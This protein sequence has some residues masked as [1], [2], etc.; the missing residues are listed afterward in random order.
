MIPINGVPKVIESFQAGDARISLISPAFKIEDRLNGSKIL[1]NLERYGRVCYKSEGRITPESAGKFLE[2]AMD[3]GHF[4]IIEHE[5]VTVRVICDRGIT[6]EWV[7]HRI[8]SYSQE[9]TRYC[10]YGKLGFQYIHLFSY[11]VG[12]L[13]Y[14]ERKK[15]I[16]DATLHYLNELKFGSAPEERKKP[17]AFCQTV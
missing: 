10:N 13:Q 16:T 12:S 15:A 17:E 7:R 11:P 5:K 1:R 2:S 4:S 14:E 6:H 3:R 8:A 9:S